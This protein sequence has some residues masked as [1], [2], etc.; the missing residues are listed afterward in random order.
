LLLSPILSIRPRIV[1]ATAMPS[2]YPAAAAAAILVALV[3]LLTLQ[4]L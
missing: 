2:S 4:V 1:L 3:L